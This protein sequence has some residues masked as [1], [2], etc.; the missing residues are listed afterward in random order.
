MFLFRQQGSKQAERK[1]KEKEG[2][3]DKYPVKA[4]AGILL[5][6]YSVYDTFDV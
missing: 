4:V 2:N 6:K 5:C 3:E 1:E